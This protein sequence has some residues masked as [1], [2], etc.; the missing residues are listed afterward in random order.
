MTCP[1][2]LGT[3]QPWRTRDNIW[4]P[5]SFLGGLVL[6]AFGILAIALG[7]VPW[8]GWALIGALAIAIVAAGVVQARRG[9]RGLCLVRRAVW[10]GLSAPGAPVRLLVNA[11]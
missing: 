4:S 11:P 2:G 9:H 5:A 3:G 8:V 7:K 1:C 10:F 6:V